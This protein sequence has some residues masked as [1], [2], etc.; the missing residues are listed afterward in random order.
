MAAI[1]HRVATVKP[2]GGPR[3]GGLG[4]RNDSNLQSIFAGSP[5]YNEYSEEAVLNAGISALSGDGGPGDSIP[6]I[7]VAAGVVTDDG[8]F[9]S[10]NLN[11][12]GAPNPA[13]VATGGGGLPA[14]AYVPNLNSAKVGSISPADQDE[15]I[16]ALPSP[17]NEYGRGP[18]TSLTPAASS[19]V[20]STQKIG[21]LI[22]GSSS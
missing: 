22:R 3:F 7:G 14:S 5:L 13:D 6:N 18:G 11:F 2:W 10:V 21:S 8:I 1:T 9:G 19:R 4:A 12:V 16:G 20:I 15:Y 17:N